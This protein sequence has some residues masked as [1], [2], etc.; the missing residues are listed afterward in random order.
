MSRWLR[1][2]MLAC[3]VTVCAALTGPPVTVRGQAD[4][5][6][7]EAG[8]P[9]VNR[10]TQSDQ[11][12]DGY[13][14][15]TTIETNFAGG[16][17][18]IL[19]FDGGEDMPASEDWRTATDFE[20]DTWVFDANSDGRAELIIQ[21]VRVDPT[22]V[23]ARIF[24]DDDGDG[25]VN[26][27][28]G[29][30][31]AA[32]VITEARFP[33]LTVTS[34]STWE[35][36]GGGLSYNLRF[37]Q[38]GLFEE[39]EVPQ[40][41]RRLMAR[42]GRPDHESIFADEDLDGIPDYV[43]SRL[44]APSP[45]TS[46]FHRTGIQV[47]VG[48]QTPRAN[49]SAIFWPLL[50]RSATD[51]TGNYFDTAPTI[52]MDWATGRLRDAGIVGYPV[53]QGYHINAL[54]YLRP[55]VRNVPDFENEMAFYDLDGDKDHR[56]E[57]FIRHRYYEAGD[58]HGE[59]VV[60][61][62]NEIRYSWTDRNPDGLFWDYKLGLAGRH[63]ITDTVRIGQFDIGMVPYE[64]LPTWVA[65]RTW[66]LAT[67]VARE[68]PGYASSEGIYEWA[69]IEDKSANDV[70]IGALT[71]GEPQSRAANPYVRGSTATPP[72]GKFSGM[73]PGFR[74]EYAFEYGIRPM[75][76][77]SPVDRR[78][79]LMRAEAGIWQVNA[80]SAVRYADSNHDGWLDTWTY[81]EVDT[82]GAIGAQRELHLTNDFLVY[83]D[84][85]QVVLRKAG[86]QPGTQEFIVPTNGQEA[87][88]LR[89]A[90]DALGQQPGAGD[91]RQMQQQFDGEEQRISGAS[92]SDVRLL[93]DGGYRFVLNLKSGVSAEGA[94]FLDL[95]GLKAGTYVVAYEPGAFSIDPITEPSYSLDLWGESE[96]G[97]WLAP[98]TSGLIRITLANLG[99]RDAKGLTLHLER[100]SPAGTVTPLGDQKVDVLAG[101]PLQLALPWPPTRAGQ[102][103]LRLWATDP[104]GKTVISDERPVQ[105]VPAQ[106][107]PTGVLNMALP[108]TETLIPVIAPL[109]LLAAAFGIVVTLVLLSNERRRR[110]A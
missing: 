69:P 84:D 62:S 48:H 42:D 94:K 58:R 107:A 5:Q 63:L 104:N 105:L 38:D 33:R 86:V 34:W 76:Y 32:A 2:G 75:L 68:G 28:V 106:A 3:A 31:T 56:P 103:T 93:T 65:E 47:N 55:G 16:N 61:A 109:G 81:V 6:P 73:R 79:H 49:A 39:E 97:R 7:E 70:Q 45:E 52:D 96:A 15:L 43:I 64:R 51:R 91:L 40:E 54:S 50:G 8:A 9:V 23:E 78:A 66:D 10:L 77:L 98:D 53:E 99:L 21:F 30:G 80:T 57:L 87:Q 102:W 82:S 92:L 24:D 83:G 72:R 11:N 110:Q 95:T 25:S 13:I 14:D 20:N 35:R 74:G 44:L 59:N 36:P 71:D 46:G 85:D 88:A 18:R 27:H 60:P 29:A 37:S 101:E 19:V 17:D 26:F 67:F 100:V 12:N 41:Q 90:V 89:A 108:S 4:P 22:S 1:S